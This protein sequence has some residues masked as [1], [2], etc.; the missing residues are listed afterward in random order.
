M[1]KM[2]KNIKY[3]N[4]N[5]QDINADW[6]KVNKILMEAAEQEIVLMKKK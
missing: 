1:E 6:N 3:L 5:L 4:L 2:G